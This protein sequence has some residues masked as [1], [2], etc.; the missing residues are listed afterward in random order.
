MVH[1]E[2]LNSDL[3]I[4]LCDSLTKVHEFHTTFIY[5]FSGSLLAE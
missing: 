2:F 5:I 1:L 3:E 4:Y